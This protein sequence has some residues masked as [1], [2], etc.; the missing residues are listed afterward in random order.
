[1]LNNTWFPK[2]VDITKD[3]SDYKNLTDAEKTAY[4][5]A[6]S[7][8]IFMDSFQTNNLI[9]NINPYVTSPEINLILVR[10]TLLC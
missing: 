2:E 8:L 10:L 4:D 6:F 7:Q 1:M 3:V 9:D 5:K